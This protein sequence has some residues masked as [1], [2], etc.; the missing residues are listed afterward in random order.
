[1]DFPTETP[2][3]DPMLQTLLLALPGSRKWMWVPV[4]PGGCGPAK[5]SV[6]PLARLSPGSVLSG[7]LHRNTLARL[8]STLSPASKSLACSPMITAG[9]AASGW[10]SIAVTKIEL[11]VASTAGTLLYGRVRR[12]VQRPDC[13]RFS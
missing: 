6:C 11:G 9:S 13:C 1:N 3:D 7:A 8:P 2:P 12:A 4:R 5:A 10:V